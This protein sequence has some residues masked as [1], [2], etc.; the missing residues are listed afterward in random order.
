MMESSNPDA[1]ITR[2][3]CVTS[4]SASRARLKLRSGS[5]IKIAINRS[6]LPSRTIR[7]M[8]GVTTMLQLHSAIDWAR[9]SKSVQQNRAAWRDPRVEDSLSYLRGLMSDVVVQLIC[10]RVAT[11]QTE[12]YR[13]WVPLGCEYTPALTTTLLVY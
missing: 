12:G 7:R 2:R 5:N 11:H 3:E 10:Q 6:A 1:L 9:V 4:C 13:G 8:N